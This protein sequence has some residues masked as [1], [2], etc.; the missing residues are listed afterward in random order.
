MFD[1][2]F[3]I[4]FAI[5][6]LLLGGLVVANAQIE[7]GEALRVDISHPFVVRDKTFPAGKYVITPIEQADGSNHLLKLQA[8][9]GK[10]SA[11]F[12]TLEK[13]LND[14]YKHT[15]LVFNHAGDEYVLTEIRVQGE[16]Q[17]NDIPETKSEKREVAVAA[18]N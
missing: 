2:S 4:L 14:P 11:V 9:N 16:E 8:Q 15:E 18:M 7:N 13:N 10:E 1:H 17:A 5:S 12:D 3:K 6:F